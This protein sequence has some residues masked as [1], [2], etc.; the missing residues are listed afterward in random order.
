MGSIA[1]LVGN[2]RSGAA[3][4]LSAL[5]AGCTCS[6]ESLIGSAGDQVDAGE[7]A[8]PDVPPDGITCFARTYGTV[9]QERAFTVDVTSTGGYVIAGSTD[10]GDG[11]DLD[12]WVVRLD[13]EGNP[14]WQRSYGGGSE[15]TIYEIH[16]TRDD[17]FVAV[18]ERLEEDSVFVWILRLDAEGGVIWEKWIQGTGHLYPLGSVAEC[19]DGGLVYAGE[20]LGA[21]LVVKLDRD[22]ELIWHHSYGTYGTEW[23][24]T[25]V[26][27][28]DGGFIVAGEAEGTT[29]TAHQ[30]LWML[31]LDG[32]GAVVWQ[33]V[34]ESSAPPDHTLP[35]ISH[36][37]ETSEGD[38]VVAGTY[39]TGPGRACALLVR[40]TADGDGIWSKCLASGEG[41]RM[42][43]YVEQTADGGFVAAG[44]WNDVTDEAW[45]AGLDGSGNLL[46]ERTYG[47][48]GPDRAGEIRVT[49]DGG[50]VMTGHTSSFGEGA[51]DAW[52]IKTGPAAYMPGDCPEG[53]GNTSSA[54][55]S[56][57]SLLI[58]ESGAAG[59]AFTLNFV[60]L[61]TEATSRP[62]HVTTLCAM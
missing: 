39:M 47:G 12:G 35:G 15:E 17:G 22:G 26:Q 30:L 51:S 9:T 57:V 61:P 31:R 50:F 46:W 62:S 42:A 56:D 43:T 23:A 33:K 52:V 28:S 36:V 13:R 53:I 34:L 32:D 7:S 21:L 14:L 54:R 10:G 44:V 58:R 2:M 41:T 60:H 55:A 29:P 24:T 49:D 45:V 8:W 19:E 37:R 20:V 27:A 18:G 16:E 3:L 48:P 6:T 1:F 5:L 40:L 38:L 25:V 4:L 59:W 11:G